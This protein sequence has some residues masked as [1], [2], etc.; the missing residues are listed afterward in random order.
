MDVGDAA[1]RIT[2]DREDTWRPI[3]IVGTAGTTAGGAIDLLP[4]LADL[5]RR[6]GLCSMWTP[7]GVAAPS[8]LR[9]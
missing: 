8:C 9:R 2:A 7:P 6:E 3:M 4:E 5:A 1:R